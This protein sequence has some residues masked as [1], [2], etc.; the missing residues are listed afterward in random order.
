MSTSEHRRLK[1]T[2]DGDNPWRRFGPYLSERQWGTVREDYSG[3]G[4]AW[5]SFP[6]DSARSRAYRWGEDGLGGLSDD[7]QFICLSVALWN[8]KDPILKE[9][10]FGLTGPEGNHGEDV[11][12]LY[13][14]L[15]AIPS[16]AYLQ[17]LY[18]YPQSAFPYEQLVAENRARSKYDPEFELIDTGVF[19]RDRY[20]DVFIEYA[21]NEPEDILL[22]VRV[23]NRG[24]V[25]APLVVVSQ[26]WFRNT[27]SWGRWPE[28][29]SLRAN[30]SDRIDVIHP[31]LGLMVLHCDGPDMLA[32]CDN[33][34]NHRRLSGLEGVSGFFKDGLNDCIVNGADRAINPAREGTKAGAI[35]R[36]SIPAGA[37]VTFR[38]RL[39]RPGHTDPFGRFDEVFALR[40][41]EAD[42]FYESVHAGIVGEDMRRVQRQALAGMLWSQQFYYYDVSQWLEGDPDQPEPPKKR[43]TGRNREWT[44]LNAAEIISMPDKWEY[45]WF[46]AWDLAFHCVPLAKVDP[47]FAKQQ[48]LLLLREWYMH[49]NGQLPAYEWALGDV[50]P[51]VHAWAAWRVF[52]IDRSQ[53]GRHAD[54]DFLERTLHKLLLNFTWWVNRKD[55][56]GLNLFQGGFLGLD[57]IGVFDRSSK[58]PVAGHI[59]QADGTAWMAMYALNLLRISLE[60]AKH[61]PV[62]EDIATKFLEHFLYIAGAMQNVGGH[63]IDLWDDQD[64]FFY[65]VLHYDHPEENRCESVQLK[66]RSLVGLTPLFVVETLDH[67]LLDRLPAFRRR[68]EWFL[69]YRPDLASLI[70]RWQEPGEGSQH[71]LSLLRGHRMKLL[72]RRMLDE[73]EFLSEFGVRSLSKYHKE[74]PYRLELAGVTHT[75]G[76]QPGESDSGL[77]GGNSNWRGPIWMPVNYLLVESLRKFHA[78]YGDDFRVECPTGSG[79]LL[80]LR[81]IAD[82]ISVRLSRLFLTDSEARRPSLGDNPT[83]RNDPRFRDNCLFYEYFHGDNGRGVGASHQTGWTGLIAMLLAESAPTNRD[84]RTLS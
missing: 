72:L 79:N 21:K 6:H 75:V 80:S 50:N 51:P 10:L 70:S 60:L 25:A 66:I 55:A 15:D 35:W 3:G 84:E 71:L 76:Y 47:D 24:P 40:R 49:P 74:N 67:D 62:Y 83:F 33:E 52:E 57:N 58:L 36:R 46:A 59:E 29:P 44:H 45:P 69:R 42:E 22:R 1:G 82:E 34:T 14:Y 7:R 11:K 2:R 20:F 73:T 77:F 9:R 8:T 64:G 61:R 26:A 23:A 68:M 30:D 17:M 56:H 41:R 31:E 43:Q 5:N 78:Y 16:H 18:K 37:E 27:W 13:Y 19:D 81:Q 32:F 28:R 65:D 53:H 63:G 4:E 48:L 39:S 12:E 54:L 38:A